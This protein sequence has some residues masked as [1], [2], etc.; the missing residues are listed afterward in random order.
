MQPIDPAMSHIARLYVD[1]PLQNAH[2]VPLEDAQGK[3]LT[4]VMR[5]SSG[6]AVR[7]FNGRDGEW[8]CALSVSGK[9]V[10]LMPKSQTRAQTH[11]PNLT[12]LFAPIKKART[13]FIIEKATELGVRTI[14]PVFTEFTQASRVRIDRFQSLAIEA[15]EQTERMDLPTIL[16]A[17]P[18]TN[19][20]EAWNPA[21]PLVFCDESADAMP[22]A[23]YHGELTEAAGGILTGPEGG[24]SP[25][26]RDFLRAQ[27]FIRPI[28]LGPRILRA[29]TAA[30]AALTLW[31]SLVGD[32]HNAPYLPET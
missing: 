14:Q 7:A 2:P 16:D 9:T 30:V 5:L 24:F 22:L 12:L 4:R 8:H 6:D 31:Q 18:L 29:E 32:W 10:S 11:A 25:R 21:L 1:Q 17:V 15:A 28:T 20:I 3:Y 13:D 26:E 27:G 19:A 23:E